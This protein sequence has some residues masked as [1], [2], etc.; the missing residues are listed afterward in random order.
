MS[1][2]FIGPGTDLPQKSQKWEYHLNF[3]SYLLW[4]LWLDIACPEKAIMNYTILS[5]ID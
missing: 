5:L 1:L 3:S 4:V 2:V